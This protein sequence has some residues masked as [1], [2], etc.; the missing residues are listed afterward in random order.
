MTTPSIITLDTQQHIAIATLNRPKVLNALNTEMVDLLL[1]AYVQW[2]NDPAVHAIVL[3]G[4]GDKAF[5]A[6]G[7]VKG[8]VALAQQGN[9]EEAVRYVV[10]SWRGAGCF[11]LDAPPHTHL[12]FF[13][14]RVCTQPGN[15]QPA[16]ATHCI[17][18]WHHNGRGCGIVCAWPHS[19]GH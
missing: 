18:R 14:T 13:P 17:D 7:D 15:P 10:L 16:Q 4:A 9:V 5:C 8:V 6:G 1:N 3:R 2:S 19:R 11:S 12:Q